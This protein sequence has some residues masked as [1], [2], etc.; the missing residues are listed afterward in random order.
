MML[1][2]RLVSSWMKHEILMITEYHLPM[3]H[4]IISQC[5]DPCVVEQLIST[6]HYRSAKKAWPVKAWSHNLHYH[7]N[8]L[9]TEKNPSPAV[10]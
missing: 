1:T 8:D 3:V 6:S 9:N 4:T 5:N 10:T 7:I 2:V